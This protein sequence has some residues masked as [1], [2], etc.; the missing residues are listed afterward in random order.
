MKNVLAVL[1]QHYQG[2]VDMEFAID[3]EPGSRSPTL[4]LHLLQCRPQTE[5]RNGTMRPVPALITPP[6]RLFVANRMVPQGH[7]AE[8]AYIVHVDPQA[9]AAL[10]ETPQR[11]EVA[12]VVGRL[13]AALEGKRFV[14]MG[15]GRWGTVNVTLGVPVTYADIFNARALIELA[16]RQRG[17]TLEPSYGT[18]FF[19]DLV[20]SQIYPLA[21]DPDEPPDALNQEFLRTARNHLADWLPAD[22]ALAGIVQV[23]DVAA[24]RPGHTLEIAMDGERALA[25]FVQR[26]A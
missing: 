1:T 25:Y 4:A 7:V 8:I 14:L 13:N 24:E 19:Q 21:L 26:E 23:I 11:H 17:M 3:I 16:M 18:H 15:P 2:L 20:E 22:A 10:T 6:D 9:Y 12:R 5:M